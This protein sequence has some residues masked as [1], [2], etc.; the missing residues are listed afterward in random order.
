[1]KR[2][3]RI[4][5]SL[6]VL[7]FCGGLAYGDYAEPPGWD[8][9]KDYFTH[10]E[11][12]FSTPQNPVGAD[13]TPIGNP[14]GLATI[15][16]KAGSYHVDRIGWQIDPVTYDPVVERFGGWAMNGPLPGDPEDPEGT[17]T[18]VINIEVPNWHDPTLLKE[19]WVEIIWCITPGAAYGVTM[20][21]DWWISDPVGDWYVDSD[22]VMIGYHE[23]GVGAWMRTWGTFAIWP[24]PESF[25][26][27]VAAAMWNDTDR[28][29]VDQIA[30]DTRCIVPEPATV[31]LLGLGGLALLRKR[32][33]A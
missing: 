12:S 30:I 26:I 7:C 9:T 2:I 25:H 14:Y 32:K 33:H 13:Y 4:I 1:M 31:A 22:D 10:Q 19:V 27:V 28:I 21:A 15:E 6:T 24:Q 29:Y 20:D 16:W 3:K 17:Y 18:H 23:D 5:L 11:W 8:P